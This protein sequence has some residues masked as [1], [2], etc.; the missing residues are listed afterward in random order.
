MNNLQD[1]AGFCRNATDNQIVNIYEKEA[2]AKRWRMARVA[3]DECTR[4]G[5]MLGNG[6][7][8]Q[9]VSIASTLMDIEHRK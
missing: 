7:G 9:V 8:H 5:I 3:R 2:R 4:R 1:F 6:K